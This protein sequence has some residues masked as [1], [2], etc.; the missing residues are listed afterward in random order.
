MKLELNLVKVNSIDAGVGKLILRKRYAVSTNIMESV[1]DFIKLNSST[2]S[3]V[4]RDARLVGALKSVN[5]LT[6]T[7]FQC[8]RYILCIGYGLDIWY[9]NVANEEA[10]SE[11]V[12]SGMYE[13]NIVD[14]DTVNEFA[15][16]SS[17]IVQV[18][19]IDLASL[20]ETVNDSFNL[21]SGNLFAGINNP[22][23]NDITA[24]KRSMELI[25]KV[26]N[27]QTTHANVM[28]DFIN[29]KVKCIVD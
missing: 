10:N 23:K 3:T 22:L 20:Y 17:K 12:D 19:N 18:E 4:V 6:I 29:K 14:L 11:G 24:M 26:P 16:F 1:E 25:G 9:W 7:E 28:L 15:P 21:F 13:Y 2:F 8:L 5:D 27:V